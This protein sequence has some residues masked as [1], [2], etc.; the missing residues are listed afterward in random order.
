MAHRQADRD[1]YD[2]IAKAATQAAAKAVVRKAAAYAKA[3]AIMPPPPPM[4]SRQVL[5]SVFERPEFYA[6]A[7]QMTRALKAA[8]AAAPP[9][10]GA[11]N[12]PHGLLDAPEGFD[13][14]D[15]QLQR[16]RT[17]GQAFAETAVRLARNLKRR[18]SEPIVN[19]RVRAGAVAADVGEANVAFANSLQRYLNEQGFP[20]E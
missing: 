11:P 8:D 4:P 14:I 1:Y 16:N 2:A 18:R 7:P 13:G 3:K 5:R 12:P 9:I 20:E 17:A 15:L 19:P 6:H 10:A